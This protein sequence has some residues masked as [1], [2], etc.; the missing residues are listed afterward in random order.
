MGLKGEINC[1]DS[2]LENAIR[3]RRKKKP[4]S[5]SVESISHSRHQR[6][7]VE[8]EKKKSSQVQ[9]FDER[10]QEQER[11]FKKVH[12]EVMLFGAKNLSKRERKKF[13]ADRLTRLGISKTKHTKIPMKIK[14]GIRA[15]QLKTLERAAREEEL[16][17]GVTFNGARKEFKEFKNRNRTFDRDYGLVSVRENPNAK[18]RETKRGMV[19]SKDLIKMINGK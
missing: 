7:R 3:N 4:S 19:V 16:V 9:T 12:N 2:M 1:N 14:Q 13:E 11:L 8:H 15:K 6:T 18:F 17:A 10:V 5:D